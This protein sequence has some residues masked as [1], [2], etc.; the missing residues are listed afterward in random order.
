M[1]SIIVIIIL[2]VS[3][4]I[5]YAQDNLFLRNDS[6]INCKIVSIFGSTINYKLLNQKELLRIPKSKVILVEYQNGKIYFFS[7]GIDEE[8]TDSLPY[9]ETE[10]ARK[11]RELEEFKNKELT[12]PNNFVGFYP[13]QLL[14]GRFTMSYERLF[15][16]KSIGV[17]VPLSIT[18]NPGNALRFMATGSTS[19]S[20]TNTTSSNNEPPPSGI[21]FIGGL[22]INYY[23]DLEPETKYYFGPRIRYGTDIL[24]GSI[25]GMTFQIQNGIMLTSGKNFATNVGFGVGFFKLSAKYA[26]FPGYSSKQV[27]PWMSITW[28]TCYRF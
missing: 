24:L 18:F 19:S 25:E 20:N 16:N 3:Y 21:G 8:E 10:A 27:Y 6:I 11:A 12:Y 4:K 2:V 26:N 15:S 1:R 14:L 22:D 17:N 5:S 28:R 23:Y 13:T 7:S 9:I